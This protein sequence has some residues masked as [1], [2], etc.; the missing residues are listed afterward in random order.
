MIGRLPRER[1]FTLIELLVVISIIALLIGILLPA[2]GTA[3]E[4]GR[5]TTCLSALRQWGIAAA[6]YMNDYKSY[7]PGENNLS[8]PSTGPDPGAWY[9]E[10]PTYVNASRYH[11]VFDGTANPTMYKNQNIWWCNTARVLYGP[12]AVTGGGNAFDYA[13]NAIL[14]GTGTYGPNRSSTIDHIRTDGLPSVSNI[15]IMSE[16]TSRV[17]TVSIGSLDDRHHGE[18]KVNV[19]FADSHVS[20]VDTVAGNTQSSGS[21]TTIWKTASDSMHWGVYAR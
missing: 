9:N 6:A 16:P 19:L 4:S 10:L 17:P 3:R 8:N 13:W 20:T 1:A 15:V 2:L 12:P 18:Q 7:L 14:N 21:T 5:S 11:Q